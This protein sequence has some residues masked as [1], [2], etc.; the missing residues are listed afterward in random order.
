LGNHKLIAKWNI[1]FDL[2][3]Q[4]LEINGKNNDCHIWQLSWSITVN[5]WKLTIKQGTIDDKTSNQC[6]THTIRVDNNAI[7][8]LEN[9]TL[10]WDRS[11]YDDIANIALVRVD[12][13]TLNIDSS[14][15]I[16][17]KNFNVEVLQ[18]SK[19]TIKWNSNFKSNNTKYYGAINMNWGSCIAEITGWIIN[20]N[21]EENKNLK[22][23]NDG[24]NKVRITGWT[25]N[26]D[27]SKWVAD[28]YLV[29]AKEWSYD[30][31]SNNPWEEIN[32][33]YIANPETLVSWTWIGESST[34]KDLTVVVEENTWIWDDYI[35]WTVNTGEI[36][37]KAKNAIP[38][39][40]VV[41]KYKKDESEIKNVKFW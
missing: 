20:V 19:I 12:K 21:S 2:N 38:L 9:L 22:L 3:D 25:F 36:Y 23:F 16:S 13:W 32:W 6:Y 18:T 8:N 27:P 26:Q 15:I 33:N 41:V 5:K 24:E 39:G 35:T 11:F 1:I 37:P 7:L 34:L 17:T 10:K 14:E 40:Q 4:I 28:G 29:V 31:V 30:V